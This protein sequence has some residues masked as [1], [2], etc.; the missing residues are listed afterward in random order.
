MI[1]QQ[2][3]DIPARNAPGGERWLTIEVPREIPAG[4][5]ILTF[6]PADQSAQQ[7]RNRELEAAAAI[8]AEDYRNDPE[9][10]AF[11]ALDGEDFLE[12]R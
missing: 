5:A 1:I 8:A 3:I 7:R 6:T 12:T 11:C 9:L 4:P 10:T 2:T